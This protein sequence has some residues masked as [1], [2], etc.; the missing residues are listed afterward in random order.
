MTWDGLQEGK[1]KALRRVPYW[2]YRNDEYRERELK[3]AR[4]TP[5]RCSAAIHG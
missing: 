4:K 3:F 1:R 2:R 5:K